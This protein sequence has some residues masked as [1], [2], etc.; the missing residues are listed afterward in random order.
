MAGGAWWALDALR[1]VVI[2]GLS[3]AAD[4]SGT[5]PPQGGCCRQACTRQAVSWR[6]SSPPPVRSELCGG[7]CWLEG[8]CGHEPAPETEC[9]LRP[10][11]NLPTTHMPPAC[12]DHTR[13]QACHGKQD[14]REP[15]ARSQPWAG[16]P[17]RRASAPARA[18]RAPVRARRRA[19][20]RRR[21]RLPPARAP[22][23]PG[24][25]RVPSSPLLSG[26]QKPGAG[27]RGQEPSACGA[28]RTMPA[29]RRFGRPISPA[30][31]AEFQQVG[32][33]APPAS[34]LRSP[35][36]SPHTPTHPHTQLTGAA[37][38]GRQAMASDSP[39]AP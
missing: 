33:P 22:Q 38:G 30:A 37:P 32:P 29:T 3:Q 2:P 15:A 23:R 26:R 18:A 8:R 25:G 20:S 28:G 31:G 16:A 5:W 39:G 1:Q 11:Y 13:T 17:S 35:T 9:V 14:S 10:R 24:R 4:R 6:L 34:F 7:F 27:V 36:P 12:P 21:P 19:W